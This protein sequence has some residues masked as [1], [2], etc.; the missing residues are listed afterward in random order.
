MKIK[1]FL[2]EAI[3][4]WLAL[5]MPALAQNSKI[6]VGLD[7]GT[8]LIQQGTLLLFDQDAGVITIA[9]SQEL[10]PK[11][12]RGRVEIGLGSVFLLRLSM[13]YGYTRDKLEYTEATTNASRYR[14]E[15]KFTAAGFPA[16]TAL[17]LQW[18][19]DN[20]RNFTA[21]FGLGGG[22]Y[23]YKFKIAGFEE[24]TA[25]VPNARDEFDKM[26]MKIS[27]LAQF[28]VAGF[29]LRLNSRFKATLEISK[30][31]LSLL[32]EKQ[33]TAGTTTPDF[34]NAITYKQTSEKDYAAAGGINDLAFSLG[35]SLNLGK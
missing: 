12:L 11:N 23:S 34:G 28:F 22:F 18:P 25:A 29:D 10:I 1:W 6:A 17:L 15:A 16:E 20:G 31:G 9:S 13:G 8:S 26:E 2:A 5:S 4:A 27:G 21:H 19:L 30:L 7:Y 32:K 24:Q 33:E 3:S 35:L 14:L